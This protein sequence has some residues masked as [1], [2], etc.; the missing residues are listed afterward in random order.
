MAPAPGSL[1][2]NT[3]VCALRDQRVY[4]ADYAKLI[5][6]KGWTTDKDDM[7]YEYFWADKDSCGQRI[8]R[9]HGLKFVQPIMCTSPDSGDCLYMFQSGSRYYIWNPIEC[10]IWEIVTEM[11]LL[12]IVTE[13]DK[14]GLKSLKSAK[15]YQVFSD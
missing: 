1:P 2:R 7:D 5:P 3:T 10:G 4:S 12:D 11:D 14:M 6:P 15:V 13:I 9:K 8:A